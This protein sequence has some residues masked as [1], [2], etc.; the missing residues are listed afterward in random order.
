M[1]ISSNLPQTFFYKK[2]PSVVLCSLFLFTGFFVGWK[3]VPGFLKANLVLIS[4][5][6]FIEILTEENNLDTIQLDIS[7]KNI[8][9]IE[10]KKL[11]A[12]TRGILIS[13]DE[14]FVKAEITHNG[15]TVGCKIRLKG[16]L[17][18]HW[19]GEKFSLRVEIKGDGL[20][21]GM[22][23]FSL[24]DPVTK[25]NTAEWLYL[26]TLKREE[27]MAVRYEFVNLIINGKSM[28]VYAIEE[29]FSKELIEFN[30]RRE[31]V[32]VGFNDYLLWKKFPKDVASNIEWNSIFRSS[33]A[34]VRNSNRVSKCKML[35]D[36]KETAFNL[37]RGMQDNK[38]TPSQIFDS[39]KLGKFL[40]ITRL[41]QAESSLLFGDINF[42]FN[43]VTCLLE[44][45][46]FDGNPKQEIKSPYCYF[47][48]GDIKD[49]W[50]NFA[51]K[52]PTIAAEYISALYKYTGVSFIIE[53]MESLGAEESHYNKILKQ[54]LL[55]NSPTAIWKN[56]PTLTKYKPWEIIHARANSIRSE[57]EEVQIL[58]TYALASE[59][60]STLKIVVRNT[61][62][63]PIEIYGFTS[64]NSFWSANKHL[65]NPQHKKTSLLETQG[66][67]I[68]Y[69]QGNGYQQS[70]EDLHFT[71]F[72]YETD[73]PLYVQC[74]FLGSPEDFVKIQIP[75]DL[76]PFKI[77]ELPLGIESST[78]Q[79]SAF[80]SLIVESNESFFI[81]SGNYT[82]DENL[83]IPPRKKL[84]ISPGTTL[85]F[86]SNV[87]LVSESPLFF[88][89][90]KD[91]PIVLSSVNKHWSGML[92][93]NTEEKSVFENVK[94]EN[95]HG[96]GKGL[97]P[98]AT[99]KN[100]WTM[101]GGIT[102]YNSNT[103]FSNCN[104]EN[105]KTEDALN[106]ISSSFTIEGCTF[107]SLFSDAFDGD[108][109]DGSLVNCNF[110]N[111]LGDGV[112][113]S[114]SNAVVRNNSFEDIGDKAISVG[115]GSHV[116]VLKCKIDNVSFGIVS[117]DLSVTKAVD[118]TIA[119]AKIA[120]F[121]AFQK[122][123]S[124]GPATIQVTN[125][126]ILDCKQLFLIQDGSVG[127][128]DDL[129]VQTS[130]FK[131]TDL[132]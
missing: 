63:Q 19:S 66:N 15:Q 127:R 49:N 116:N 71:I 36:Q 72:D 61:T 80:T 29:H 104:F 124:F 39:A 16:D 32:I 50:V 2:Y 28:G 6:K 55:M 33:G 60:K 62:T 3:N 121:A 59:K 126:K 48:W 131:T 64:S 42:Y 112:D 10:A 1:R 52:D 73:L 54:E 100:G 41:W 37:L 31:G 20:V 103:Q 44:P 51:L 99:N 105:F 101:T 11:D 118:N 110:S 69:S 47:T 65:S 30:E 129:I 132:Y 122:K 94:F 125:P 74:R 98:E 27:C 89:G 119:N 77:N 8:K 25:N 68:L 113:F 86:E 95:V 46:G 24:Q 76:N 57:L 107:S 34:K 17:S 84:Y 4:K 22:S 35:N 67:L 88:Y 85:L 23:R 91:R 14:D 9:K 83:Y 40:A 115:E 38:L 96:V 109:V 130:A 56:H 7:F 87:T 102:V 53:L 13:S 93:Y 21:K 5:I 58:Q 81:P 70:S 26:K 111:I 78:Y 45:I 75:C 106:I 108:F 43:P 120:A 12:K 114:G 123:N 117:K 92:L 90:T 97:N 18:D 128:L 79:N 82:V